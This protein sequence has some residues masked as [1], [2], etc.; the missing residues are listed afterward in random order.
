M[1]LDDL[2]GKVMK[3]RDGGIGVSLLSDE[4]RETGYNVSAIKGRVV[5][6]KSLV[7]YG[8]GDKYGSVYFTKREAECMVLLLKGKT[9]SN[10]ANVLNLSPRTVEYYIKNMKSKLGCRTKFELVEMVYAS[11]FMQ[12]IDF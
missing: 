4:E 6:V 11:E 7:V 10:V 5:G 9:I 8:L 3:G 2:L 1:P 12:R